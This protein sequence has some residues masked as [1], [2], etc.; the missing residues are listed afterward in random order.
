[1]TAS[2]LLALV[3]ATADPVGSPEV[4][5]E[6]SV[7]VHAARL[8]LPSIGTVTA[9]SERCRA[10]LAGIDLGPAPIPGASTVV[11]SSEIEAYV[12][13]SVQASAP[14]C[15][16]VL[17]GESRVVINSD[18]ESADMDGLLHEAQAALQT[19]LSDRFEKVTVAPDDQSSRPF[20][21]LPGTRYEFSL[22]DTAHPRARS[23]VDVIVHEPGHAAWR[24]PLWF[25]VEASQRCWQ[26]DE[27]VTDGHPVEAARKHLALVDIA[28]LRG[29][30]IPGDFAF[31]QEVAARPLSAGTILTR[32]DVARLPDVL[33]GRDVVLRFQSRG[34]AVQT[35]AIA[36]ESGNQGDRVRVRNKR[37]GE[38]TVGDVVG[39]NDVQVIP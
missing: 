9:A 30:A 33:A 10:L 31:T 20:A 26:L 6:S 23:V 19:A 11:R 17:R 2:M 37:S 39:R 28:N 5:L 27:T 21:V 8:T 22:Q 32:E 36:L 16:P 25:A 24:Y 29:E 3:T 18:G 1:M 38:E 35:Q 12:N 15:V 7:H 4:S 13:A 34:L 14:D